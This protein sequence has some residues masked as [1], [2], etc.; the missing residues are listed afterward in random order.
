MP[1]LRSQSTDRVCVQLVN[2][3]QYY[4]SKMGQLTWLT[5]EW[6]RGTLKQRYESRLDAA[7]VR[8]HQLKVYFA[9]LKRLNSLAGIDSKKPRPDKVL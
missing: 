7:M 5:S 9:K 1:T 3:S 6:L 4:K 2:K 8:Q